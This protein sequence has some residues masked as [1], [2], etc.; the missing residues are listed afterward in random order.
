MAA[1]SFGNDVTA[2]GVPVTGHL[3]VA[4]AGTTLP[5]LG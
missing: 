3:G 2:V 4:P 5:D 1:D